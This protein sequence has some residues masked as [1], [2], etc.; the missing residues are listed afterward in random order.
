MRTVAGGGNF[1]SLFLHQ[2][3][4]EDEEGHR[5]MGEGKEQRLVMM[6]A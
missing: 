3:V 4:R 5:K 2:T 6:I 1:K